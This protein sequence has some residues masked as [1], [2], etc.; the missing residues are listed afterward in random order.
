MIVYLV[1]NQINE[2]IIDQLKRTGV[3]ENI[4]AQIREQT[5]KLSDDDISGYVRLIYNTSETNAILMH[6]YRDYLSDLSEKLEPLNLAAEQAKDEVIKR[7]LKW[8][9]ENKIEDLSMHHL[10]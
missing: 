10:N 1:Q 7:V 3:T 6:D 2:S 4:L 5:N 9:R 8:K